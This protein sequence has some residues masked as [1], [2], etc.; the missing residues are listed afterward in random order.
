MVWVVAMSLSQGNIPSISSFICKEI[1]PASLRSFV[2]K[3]TQHLFVHLLYQ[4]PATPSTNIHYLHSDFLFVNLFLRECSL[5][6]R[7]VSKAKRSEW[8]NGHVS[9]KQGK[10]K[11]ENKPGRNLHNVRLKSLYFLPHQDLIPK[12]SVWTEEHFQLRNWCHYIYQ[13]S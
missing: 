11:E 3:Y 8:K 5:N 7:R 10:T 2:W 6:E 12:A 4:K 1:Y 13:I 9:T